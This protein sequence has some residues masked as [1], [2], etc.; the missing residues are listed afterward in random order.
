MYCV[1]VQ[2][3]G[4]A[5]VNVLAEL[6]S[7]EGREGESVHA[8]VLASGRLLAVLGIPW[9]VK[10]SLPSFLPSSSHGVFPVCVCV[11][12]CPFN[13]NTSHVGLGPTL[14]QNYLILTNYICYNPVPK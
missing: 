5:K 9:L 3:A 7:S 8:S 11:P 4:C 12:I 1:T 2:E 6:V 13:T 10:A 14:L